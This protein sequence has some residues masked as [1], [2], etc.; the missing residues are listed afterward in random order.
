MTFTESY[1]DNSLASILNDGTI[2]LPVSNSYQAARILPPV[3]IHDEEKQFII[4]TE[5]PGIPKDQIRID[6]EGNNLLIKGEI[7]SE[8]PFD[9][10][11]WKVRE[12]TFGKFE[13]RIHLPKTVCLENIQTKYENGILIVTLDKES[14]KNVEIK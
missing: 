13:R 12:R 7:K 9:D 11:T 14:V 8:K 5:I 2:C 6:I 3:D 1:F 10:K 4:K